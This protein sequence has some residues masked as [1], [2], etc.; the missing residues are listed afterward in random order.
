MTDDPIL[1]AKNMVF[2]MQLELRC[3]GLTPER[4]S[5]F[6]SRLEGYLIE[7]SPPPSDALGAVELAARTAHQLRARQT[8][9]PTG[10]TGDAQRTPGV[11]VAHLFAIQGGRA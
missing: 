6:L 2:R 3:G 5:Q 8:G 4:A 11:R 1:K 9:R 10:H 7:A